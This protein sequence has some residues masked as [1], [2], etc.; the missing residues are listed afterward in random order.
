MEYIGLIEL[1]Y[2]VTPPHCQ[3]KKLGCIWKTLEGL[4]SY[5]EKVCG[6]KSEVECPDCSKPSIK[7]TSF[8]F[9]NK[10]TRSI[11]PYSQSKP[12]KGARDGKIH[13]IGKRA[14]YDRC[15][16]YL[17]KADLF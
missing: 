7:L 8:C 2:I 4:I 9:G 12:A 17:A 10:I 11:D 5:V 16:D 6:L 1:P 3:D 14:P 13:S 15:D